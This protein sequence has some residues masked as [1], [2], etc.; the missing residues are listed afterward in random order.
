VEED[1][2]MVAN[3]RAEEAARRIEE[4]ERMYKRM[5]REK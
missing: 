1:P 5:E 3:C 2:R 4:R